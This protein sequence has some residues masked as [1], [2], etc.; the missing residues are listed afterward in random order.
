MSKRCCRWRYNPP[1][2]GEAHPEKVSSRVSKALSLSQ[3]AHA[4][5]TKKS[6]IRKLKMKNTE[7]KTERL[8][9]YLTQEQVEK[10]EKTKELMMEFHEDLPNISNNAFLGKL[11]NIGLRKIDEDLQ[12]AQHIRDTG[13]IPVGLQALT[14]VQQALE[15]R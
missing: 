15:D 11:I 14:D 13:L 7:R 4:L 9:L 1:I 12:V 6:Q 3:Y 2:G 10:C 8:S 5:H